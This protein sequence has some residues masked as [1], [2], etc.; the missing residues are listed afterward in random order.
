MKVWGLICFFTMVSLVAMGRQFQLPEIQETYQTNIGETIR[1]PIKITNQSDKPLFYIIR[2]AQSDLGE[3]QKGYF[4]L[5]K[6][7]LDTGIS[8]FSK[9]IEPGETIQQ[10]AFVLQSG[11]IASQH[12]IKF[13]IFPKGNQT[14]MQEYTVYINVHERTEKP[15]LFHSKDITIQD[16]YPNPVQ[17]YAYIDYRIHN[18]NTK[19]KLTIHNILGKP[20]DEVELPTSETR[21]KLQ[22]E[23]FTSGIYFYTLYLDNNGVLTRKLIIRK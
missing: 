14:E 11:L 2:K 13:Q 17:D 3:S 21:I 15:V 23:E 22:T 6:N 9:R 7:C 8:E 1:I 20:M 4:C 10:L 16:V 19:A 18:E 12:A 5:D